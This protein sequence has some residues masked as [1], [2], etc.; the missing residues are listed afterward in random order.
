M[1]PPLAD[2]F[3]K[4]VDIFGRN[5]PALARKHAER[6]SQ[7]QHRVER[8][9][10]V[11]LAVAHELAIVE[12]DFAVARERQIH[13]V[14]GRRG[15]VGRKPSD[16]G[17]PRRPKDGRARRP[18]EVL[19]KPFAVQVSCGEL[20]VDR[21]QRAALGIHHL[22]APDHARERRVLLQDRDARVDGAGQQL[23]V[24]V[25]EDDEPPRRRGE[26][27]VARGA[28]PRRSPGERRARLEPQQFRQNRRSTRRRRR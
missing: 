1:L 24:G 13:G 4:R 15:G 20:G 8:H 9:V 10:A 2:A 19:V 21:F 18:H 14:I 17:D 28:K 26:T 27:G 25:E 12:P 16:R 5:V 3:A 23:V 11:V 7:H 6:R 22:T